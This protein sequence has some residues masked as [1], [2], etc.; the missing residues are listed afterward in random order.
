MLIPEGPTSYGISAL[1]EAS[2]LATKMVANYGLTELGIT[3]F[4]PPLHGSGNS[5]NKYETAVDEIDD[6]MFGTSGDYFATPV[7]EETAG[8]IKEAAQKLLLEAYEEDLV[9]LSSLLPRRRLS[10]LW[11]TPD[12]HPHKH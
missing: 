9:C 11:M 4:A 7:P 6:D 12:G 2:G 1:I 5:G 10:P 3:T 8:Q